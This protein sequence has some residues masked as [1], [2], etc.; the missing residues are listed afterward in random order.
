MGNCQI[1]SELLQLRMEKEILK[2]VWSAAICQRILLLFDY[3]GQ[4]K[5]IRTVC[6]L[7]KVTSSVLDEDPRTSCLKRPMSF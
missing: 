1:R 5:C 2:N 7:F 4:H 3:V 6:E